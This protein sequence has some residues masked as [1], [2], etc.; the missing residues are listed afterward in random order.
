M[1]TTTSWRIFRK[2]DGNIWSDYYLPFRIVRFSISE[3]SFEVVMTNLDPENFPSEELKPLCGM[4]QGIETAFRELKYTIGLLH[5]HAKKWSTYAGKLL[6]DSSCTTFPNGLPRT[7]P[8][9]KQ[10]ENTL[11]KPIFLLRYRFADNSFPVMYLHQMLKLSSGGIFLPFVPAEA[12]L[13]I[14][15]LKKRSSSFIG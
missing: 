12:G 7:Q 5:F 6:P 3:N 8:F 10:T 15:P 4:R 14:W 1:K 11:V 13:G 9:K 2:K